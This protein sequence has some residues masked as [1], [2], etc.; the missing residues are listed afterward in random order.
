M[1]DDVGAGRSRSRRDPSDRPTRSGQFLIRALLRGDLE[2]RTADARFIPL[3]PIMEDLFFS[4]IEEIP[5][6]TSVHHQQ[7]DEPPP[8]YNTIRR[9]EGTLMAELREATEQLRLSLYANTDEETRAQMKQFWDEEFNAISEEATIERGL[10]WMRA[11]VVEAFNTHSGANVVEYELE[12]ISH[13][14]LIFDDC[15]K[16]YH[17]YNFIM[18]SKGPDSY[19]EGSCRFFAEVKVVD[20]ERHYFCCPIQPDDDGHCHGCQNSGI[21]LKHPSDG[22]YEEGNADSGFPFD[23]I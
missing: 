8:S 2:E 4:G 15:A 16:S 20:G 11:E 6:D 19:L 13:Q 10:E 22:G 23:P 3:T 18:K 7:T 17:H 5:E 9:G 12:D 21:D 1:A 14:C